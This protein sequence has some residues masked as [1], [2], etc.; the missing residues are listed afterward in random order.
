MHNGYSW[1]SCFTEGTWNMTK[2]TV[3]KIITDFYSTQRHEA[4]LGE[5]KQR[6]FDRYMERLHE[7]REEG[8]AKYPTGNFFIE[9]CPKRE[10][11]MPQILPRLLGQARATCPTPF[12]DQDVYLY[13]RKDEYYELIWTLPFIEKCIELKRDAL[14][15]NQ[16]DRDVLKFVLDY[17][18]GILYRLMKILNK[19]K[20]NSLELEN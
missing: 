3:G 16:A 4:E 18:S 13:N 2:E 8:K 7:L 11:N 19:E 1:N 20:P 17:E 15:L 14:I 12:L 6:E 5:I 9:I 10:R